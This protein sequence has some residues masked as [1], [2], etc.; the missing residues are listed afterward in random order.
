M[1]AMVETL[2]EMQPFAKLVDLQSDAGRKLKQKEYL[3]EGILPVVDQGATLIGGYTDDESLRYTGPLPVVVFGDHTRNFKLIDFPF[4]VG[5]DGVKLLAPK[6]G[7]DASYLYY[8]LLAVELPNRGYSRHL[9]F[10]KKTELPLAPLPEQRRIVEAIELQLG[11]LDAAVARLHAAKA[12]LK[13]YKQA[14]LKA[15]YTGQLWTEGAD[16]SDEAPLPEGWRW[17][18]LGDFVKIR[19][20]YAFKSTDYLDEGVL[21]I[22]QSNLGGEEVTTEGAKYLPPSYLEAHK[23]FQVHKGDILIGMSGSIGKLCTYDLNEP[24]L[25]N[26]RTGLL[27]FK[28]P[29]QK[30]WV[31]NYLPMLEQSLLKQGK[32]VAVLNISAK[33]IEASPMPIPPV[34][35]QSRIIDEVE[36]R[37]ATIAE[38]EATLDA[39]LQQAVRLRQ[40]VLKRAFEGRLV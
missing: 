38:T 7:V 16:M 17:G 1:E 25:Q 35:V 5:A 23:D 29:K 20:G 39:Q 11:R 2:H 12:K 10:L 19:N 15:A 37:I 4:A 36:H 32:G 40:A 21:L 13:R 22:R 6:E 31:W 14:V 33:Q 34:V 28:D 30:P 18:T 9:Q 26:Q 8:M 27:Q 3:T 24:A